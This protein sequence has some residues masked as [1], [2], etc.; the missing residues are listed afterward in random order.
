MNHISLVLRSRESHSVA[1]RLWEVSTVSFIGHVS[2]RRTRLVGLLCS[3]ILVIYGSL[4]YSINITNAL[5]QSTS[6]GSTMNSHSW[7]DRGIITG[8]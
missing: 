3:A 6:A 5:S 2:S 4:D 8:T 1:P 7:A